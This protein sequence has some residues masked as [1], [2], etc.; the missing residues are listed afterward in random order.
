MTDWLSFLE[1]MACILIIAPPLI[2]QLILYPIAK[3]FFKKIPSH[4]IYS[5]CL[6]INTILLII[7]K[8]WLLSSPDPSEMDPMDA[9]DGMIITIL[10]APWYIGILISCII[11]NVTA[12][13]SEKEDEI[14]QNKVNSELNSD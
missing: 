4:K 2:I 11:R 9:F 5:V 1:F 13:K 7:F 6:V 3:L 8:K 14:D 10:W 12:K